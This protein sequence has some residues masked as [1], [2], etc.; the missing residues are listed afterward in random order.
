MSLSFL[1]R[2][3]SVVS[4]AILLLVILL[5]VSFLV[6]PLLAQYEKYQ[7][8]LSKDAR[9]LQQL[10]AVVQSKE[11]LQQAYQVFETQKLSSWLY[12]LNDPAAVALDIQRRVSTEIA[13]N[14]GQLRTISPM[15]TKRE[16][17]YLLVGVQVHFT[18]SLEAVMQM[19]K[20]LETDKP[21]L[22]VES[23]R[24]TPI[25]YRPRA[26]EPDKQLVDVQM[27]VATF[28]RSEF[29]KGEEP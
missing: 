6:T 21:L 7:F 15:P 29:S 11:E 27:S 25:A 28:V 4:V 26:D 16:D 13:K 10:G 2:R 9:V 19:L 12:N 22:T 20:V 8:E 14:S 5:S 3:D 17:D 23:L 24:L 18:A 1:N